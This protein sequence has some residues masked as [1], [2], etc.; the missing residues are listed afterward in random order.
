MLVDD[1]VRQ[2]GRGGQRRPQPVGSVLLQHA[3]GVLPVGQSGGGG[4]GAGGAATLPLAEV[5]TALDLL[6]A[7]SVPGRLVLQPSPEDPC[8]S[9]GPGTPGRR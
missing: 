6:R 3:G 1:A 4:P 7:G 2:R 9:T 8:R 5:N